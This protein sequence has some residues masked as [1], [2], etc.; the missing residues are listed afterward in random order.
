MSTNYYLVT[1]DVSERGVDVKV[2]KHIGKSTSYFIFQVQLE[3]MTVKECLDYIELV[4]GRT[5]IFRE[6][7][8]YDEYH[9]EDEYGHYVDIEELRKAIEPGQIPPDK[10]KQY[11]EPHRGHYVDNGFLFSFNEFT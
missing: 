2:R 5:A 9:I 4:L 6:N 3:W 1:S 11:Y 7:Q 8:R 10:F